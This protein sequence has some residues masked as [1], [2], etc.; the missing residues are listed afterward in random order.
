MTTLYILLLTLFPQHQVRFGQWGQ[1]IEVIADRDTTIFYRDH[2]M[3][4]GQTWVIQSD[5]LKISQ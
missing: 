1:T 5:T 3:S 4:T 2:S